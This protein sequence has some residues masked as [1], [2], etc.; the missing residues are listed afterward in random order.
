MSTKTIQ[1]ENITTIDSDSNYSDG[2]ST[3][4]SGQTTE[5]SKITTGGC[6]EI[7]QRE[8]I[9]SDN[10]GVDNAIANSLRIQPG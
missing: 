6:Q 2:T 10:R 5:R 1:S 7:E 3:S 9:L 4:F 8:Y